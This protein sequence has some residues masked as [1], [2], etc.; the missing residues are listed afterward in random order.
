MCK[1]LNIDTYLR[2]N[3]LVNNAQT[4]VLSFSITVGHSLR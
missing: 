1:R 3:A 2:V 4:F